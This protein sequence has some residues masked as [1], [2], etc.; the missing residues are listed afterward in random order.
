MK[1]FQEKYREFTEQN[2]QLYNEV[3]EVQKYRNIFAEV[4]LKDLRFAVDKKL[5]IS[6]VLMKG[7][8]LKNRCIPT[9]E[10]DSNTDISGLYNT[11]ILT[12]ITPET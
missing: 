7:I 10:G 12:A 9:G 6:S 5:D 11:Y 3:V 1:F 2:E 8:S 4:N